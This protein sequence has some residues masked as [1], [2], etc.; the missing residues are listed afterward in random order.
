[1]I[2]FKSRG[3]MMP[4]IICPLCNHGNDVYDFLSYRNA[5]EVFRG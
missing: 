1:M 5:K 3:P 2:K 4:H